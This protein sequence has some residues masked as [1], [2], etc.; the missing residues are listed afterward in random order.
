M[1]HG[2]KLL[3]AN[4]YELLIHIHAGSNSCVECEPGEAILKLNKSK[5]TADPIKPN[6]TMMSKSQERRRTM[7]EMK[8][9]YGIEKAS[10]VSMQQ[11]DRADERRK[12][13]EAKREIVEKE[14][15][16]IGM[17]MLMKMGWKEGKGLGKNEDGIAEPVCTLFFSAAIY[18]NK[19]FDLGFC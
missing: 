10:A 2:D 11:R 8:K 9:K 6:P 19:C 13:S 1:G 16:N 18:S 14:T 17:K 12:E 4:L 5:R 3:I 15:S 7:N